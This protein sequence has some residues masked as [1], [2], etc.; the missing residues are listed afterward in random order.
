MTWRGSPVPSPLLSLSPA[1]MASICSLTCGRRLLIG[2]RT[3]GSRIGRLRFLVFRWPR[4]V[5]VI[6][7]LVLDGRLV[8]PHGRSA[9]VMLDILFW[10]AS[11]RSRRGSCRAPVLHE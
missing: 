8:R 2:V 10:R 9:L 5:V 11:G 3:G 6:R 4:V 7:A 1:L